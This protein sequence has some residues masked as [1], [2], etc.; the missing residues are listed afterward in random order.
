[1]HTQN[2]GNS[3]SEENDALP[4]ICTANFVSSIA[5]KQT[6]QEPLLTRARPRCDET[7]ACGSGKIAGAAAAVDRLLRIAA[8]DGVEGDAGTSAFFL[9]SSIA[10]RE[11]EVRT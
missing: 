6:L 8:L 3:L 9:W 7:T 2:A 10:A 4:S 1:M 11:A 5:D